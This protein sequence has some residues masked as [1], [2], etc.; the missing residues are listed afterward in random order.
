[1]QDVIAPLCSGATVSFA[2]PDAMKG[3]LKNTLEVK[4]M[5]VY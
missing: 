1:M 4:M 3:T 2:Q 5:C